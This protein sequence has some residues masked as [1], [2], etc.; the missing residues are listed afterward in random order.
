MYSDCYIQAALG[1]GQVP[2]F[3][4]RV[5]RNEIAYIVSPIDDLNNITFYLYAAPLY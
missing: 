3:K 1:S 2:N 4:Q 5:K